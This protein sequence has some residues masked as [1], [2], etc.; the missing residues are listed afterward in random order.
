V[1]A[2]L[3]TQLFGKPPVLMIAAAIVGLLGAIPGMPNFVFLLIATGLG[4]L[5]IFATTSSQT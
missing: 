2:Q 5:A 3:L 1:G 4:F